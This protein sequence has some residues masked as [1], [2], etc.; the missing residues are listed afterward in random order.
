ML[1]KISVVEMKLFFTTSVMSFQQFIIGGVYGFSAVILP[2]LELPDAFVKVDADQASWIASLPLLLSPIGSLVFGYLSDRFGR[3]LSLQ[4]TYVPLLISWSLL[5]NAESLKDIYIGRLLTGLATGTGGVI[6]V[7]IAETSPTNSRPF[8]LLIYTLF[9]GLG[10]MTSAILGALLHWRTV[11]AVY[12]VMCVIGFVA[13]FFVPS[14]P[15]WLRSRKREEEAR[16]AEKWFGFQL[17]RIDDLPTLPPPPCASAAMAT[18]T[19]ADSTVGAIMETNVSCWGTYT[20]PTVWKPMLASFAFFCCQQASGFYV[21][22]FY[23]VDVMRDCRVSIDGMTAAVYLCAARLAGTIVSL[24]FQS[25]RKRTLTTVSGLGMCVSL[26]TVVGYLYA[27]DGVSAPPATD[28]L[29][30]PF[31]FYVFFAMFA[32]LPLP[33]S[34]CG[35]M[36]PMAVKGTINGVMYSCGYELMF[37]AIKVYPMLVHMFGIRAVWTGC[38]CTCFITS[39]FGAFVL[40]ETTGKTLNEITDGFRSS[41]DKARKKIVKPQ[42]P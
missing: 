16:L 41:S 25:A 2:Q 8:F 13:P 39:L 23:S 11:A 20:S 21:L 17:D 28:L 9:V 38:A 19:R 4:L 32:V 42:I 35:E 29:I 6:Y 34:A 5:S 10:L 14:T 7:Y 24:M 3:K 31:M 40:P 15:M 37:G 36:F 30:V 22:L 33:W 12:A 18:L 26:S 1:N 27:F